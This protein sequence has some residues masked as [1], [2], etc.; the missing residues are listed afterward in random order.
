MKVRQAVVM[1]GG[2]GTRLRPLTNDR[3]KPILPVLDRP[4]LSYLIESLAKGGIEEVMLACGYRSEK[5]A[6]AIGDGSGEGT[7]ITYAYEDEPMG[8][9]GAIK[10]LEDKLDE[11]FVAVNGDV[12]ADIDLKG[13]IDSHKRTKASITIS[14][15]RV[16]DPCEFGIARLDAGGRITEFKEK[17]R[18]EEVFSDL[19]N[20]GVYVMQKDILR[21]VPKGTKYDLS[22]ELTPDLMA[23]GHRIQGHMISGLWMDVGRPRDLLGAN[24]AAAERLFGKKDWKDAISDSKITKPF[25]LGDGGKVTGSEI[26]SSVIS[27]GSSVASSEISGSL[28]MADCDISGAVIS[29][30]IIG[31]GCTVG[32]GT[33]VIDSVIADNVNLCNKEFIKGRT[34]DR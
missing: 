27:K 9:A 21:Y 26:S 22:K 12:F 5:M 33:T 4:C 14:L 8:T 29:G 15:T 10:L 16:K 1:V 3:P 6:A 13:E 17:P 30:S 34:V 11:T 24:I 20:A 31:E 2:M 18:P 32:P 23:K 7:S 28:I 25:Y 19:I